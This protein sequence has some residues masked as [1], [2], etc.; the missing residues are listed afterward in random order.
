MLGRAGRRLNF[1]SQFVSASSSVP[2]VDSCSPSS[3]VMS[4]KLMAKLKVYLVYNLLRPQDPV[5]LWRL[6]GHVG[7]SYC[8]KLWAVLLPRKEGT[9][10]RGFDWGAAAFTPLEG[11]YRAKSSTLQSEGPWMTEAGHLHLFL[12]ALTPATLNL[13]DL[14][15]FSWELYVFIQMPAKP[16][17]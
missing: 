11:Q 9:R 5:E 13:L 16:F 3:C 15:S 2:E 8:Q 6:C 12:W 14:T 17:M 7:C 10:R 4:S 1:G